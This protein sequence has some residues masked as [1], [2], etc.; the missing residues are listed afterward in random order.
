M[1]WFDIWAQLWW[2]GY[3]PTMPPWLSAIFNLMG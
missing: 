1:T 2:F 3:I